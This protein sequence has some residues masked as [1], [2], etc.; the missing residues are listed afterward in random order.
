MIPTPHVSVIVPCR[1]EVHSI[2]SSIESI[3]AQQ[4]PEGDFEIVV[5]DG[6]SSDGT[7]AVLGSLMAQH[8][9]L[10]VV[11]NAPG[12]VSTGLNAAIQAARGSVIIRM[13]AH[14]KYAPDYLVRCL[15]VLNRTG[16]D[17]VGGPWRAVGR[18]GVAQA[19]A[20][21]FHSWLSTGGGAAHK[22]TYEG[23]VDTVYLGCW[24]KTLFDKIGYFDEELVRNQ[25]DEL[26]LR[27]VRAGG[28]I[29]Q[30]PSI[31]CEYECRS[32]LKALTR[33]FYQYGYWKVRV[34][35]KHTLPAS[36]RHLAPA[37][38]LFVASAVTLAALLS[39]SAALIAA[40]C[41]LAYLVI[42]LV[43]G[44]RLAASHGWRLWPVITVTFPCYHFGYAV[45]FLHGLWDF[46]LFR[47]PARRAATSLT[48]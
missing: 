23:L 33:Q 15:D 29:W 25:D 18:E 36:L 9:R 46:S 21:S 20:A 40:V 16:A 24:R 37:A 44:L 8:S 2:R 28:V 13:D 22:L 42:I 12:I 1:N 4:P 6:I 32:S 30:S 3:L 48:R 45:G 35:Q 41:W 10:R 39:S 38:A 34:I 5:A 19:I 7:S 31:R 11:K 17:N 26:N 47:R 27:I 43:E 14:T